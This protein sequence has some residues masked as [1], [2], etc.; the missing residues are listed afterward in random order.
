MTSKITDY[1]V[2]EATDRRGINDVGERMLAHGWVPCGGVSVAT[3][4]G[5]PPA[6]VFV[7]AWIK[8]EDPDP[9][10]LL[11]RSIGILHLNIRSQRACWHFKLK[12][13]GDLVRMTADQLL[14]APDFGISS[15]TEIR[16]KLG[17][18]GLRLK[19]DPEE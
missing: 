16:K 12:I 15:L 4:Q 11:R 18:Y 19:E 8:Y 14:D 6:T 1:T 7:Q 17:A 2:V 3:M 9:P 13:L 5:T 10:A